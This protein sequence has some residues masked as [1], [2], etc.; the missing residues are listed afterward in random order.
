MNTVNETDGLRLLRE[1]CEQH[2]IGPSALGRGVGVSHVTAIGYLGGTK[3]PD[4][5]RR[6]AIERFTSGHVPATAWRT[7][8]ERRA[9]EAVQPLPTGTDG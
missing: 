6:E 8:E 1:W 3:R 9:V 2:G 5:D 7:E 4:A